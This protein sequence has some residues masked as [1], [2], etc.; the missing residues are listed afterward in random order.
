M[1]IQI[2]QF[3]LISFDANA[4]IHFACVQTIDDTVTETAIY[5]SAANAPYTLSKATSALDDLLSEPEFIEDETYHSL[6]AAFAALMRSHLR[7]PLDA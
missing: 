3:N 2:P 6:H 5:Q 4:V 1:Q 7:V